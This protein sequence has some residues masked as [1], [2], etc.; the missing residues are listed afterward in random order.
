SFLCRD[1]LRTGNR[2]VSG[3]GFADI[4]KGTRNSTGTDVCL[5]A[6]RVFTCGHG[7]DDT[8][9]VR[10]QRLRHR[11]VLPLLGVCTNA[12]EQSFYLISPWMSNGNILDF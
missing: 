6:L 5:K 8:L 3:G 2:P 7:R 12:L 4:W 9:K 1:V 11:H 10:R